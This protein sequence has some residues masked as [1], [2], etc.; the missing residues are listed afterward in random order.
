VRLGKSARKRSASIERIKEDEMAL[1]IYQNVMSLNS[2]RH[3]GIS[4]GAMG[5]SLE[6]LS[7]GLR[8]N[9]A[10]DDA[11]GLAISEKL[12]G[13]ISG[14]K[15]ASMNALDGISMLQTAEGALQEVS[16]MIQRMREL[17]VQAANGA[18]SANDR[19]ELQKEVEQLK[20]EIDRISTA[21]EFNTKKLLNG[22]GTAIWSASSDRV[23]AI[24]QGKVDEG[25]YEITLEST[26]GK[27]QIFKTQIMTLS[28]DM[29]GA[30]IV[31]AGASSGNATN[32]LN[33]TNPTSMPV[34]G[35]SY[36]TIDINSGSA[37]STDA[38]TPL[39]YYS[40][41]GSAFVVN[42]APTITTDT[43]SGYV[44]F[45]FDA[46]YD[47]VTAQ[48]GAG[49]FRF[50]DAKT[51]EI[52]EWFTAVATNSANASTI[53]VSGTATID[54][55]SLVFEFDVALDTAGK[56]NEGDKILLSITDGVA[57]GNYAASGGGTIQIS[58]GPVGQAGPIITYTG[59][60]SLTKADNTDA[61]QD[62][63]SSLIYYASLNEESGNMDLGS[64][65]MNFKENTGTGSAG[66]TLTDTFNLKIAGSGEAAPSTTKL[67]NIESFIDSDGNNVFEN[68]QE[69]TIWGNG[70][71]AIVYLEGDDT[72]SEMEGKITDAL[73]ELGMG[74]TNSEVNN[75]LVDYVTTP[76]ASGPRTVKGTF[77]IQTAM[78]GEQ[79]EIAFS[80]DQRL[81]EAFALNEIQASENNTTKVTF[82]DAHTGQLIA[83]DETGDDKVSGIIN[84][85]QL[86]FDSRAGVVES[87]DSTDGEIDFTENTTASSNVHYFHVVDNSTDLQI[88][89][90]SGQTLDINIPQLDVEGLGLEN[91]Y[92]VSQKLAQ[93]AIPDLDLALGRIVTL[94]ATI[95]AQVNRLE[96]T[97]NSLD[98]ATENMTASESRIRDLD[99]ASEMATF[100]RYQILNQS[101]ISM[102]AQANQIPQMALSLLQ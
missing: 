59:V 96:H 8:I 102:L 94:R 73:I 65:N 41:D 84:G 86:V 45:E 58:G 9:H 85:V 40:Q 70:D 90:N 72:I 52:S 46:D 14:L 35:T 60:E 62:V 55:N 61:Y 26:P 32:V 79:G 22:D 78:T 20:D 28:E 68:K 88:G 91:V 43:G 48:A 15:R 37:G 30:E 51:G 34:T 97:I 67:K 4:Q 47:T 83:T 31:T 54:G 49:R 13:Q 100:T 69:L 36:F 75:H 77:I 101:G 92:L 95:G 42:A 87:W 27:N 11:S 89:P 57:A 10:S 63:Q 25:N 39:A 50:I 2:Q 98:V 76:D 99:I 5:K 24:I 71:S 81:I 80:G 82:R 17:A 93:K 12:R 33:I 38:A 21:T 16:V 18:Y 56:V 66:A 44:E 3:L 53:V 64:F 23:R 74:S 19:V 7:S 1:R 6:R 29:I